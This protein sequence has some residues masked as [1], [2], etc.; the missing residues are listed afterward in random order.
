MLTLSSISTNGEPHVIIMKDNMLL[1]K[2]E[3]NGGSLK[4]LKSEHPSMYRRRVSSLGIREQSGRRRK[5][6]LLEEEETLMI[7]R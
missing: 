3:L 1:L 6:K 5:K 7:V 4:G 2:L